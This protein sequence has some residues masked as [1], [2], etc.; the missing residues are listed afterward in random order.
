MGIPRTSFLFDMPPDGGPRD[1]VSRLEDDDFFPM[2][3][4]K[5]RF[6]VCDE[7]LCMEG[8]E[9]IPPKEPLANCAWSWG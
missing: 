9:R 5:D 3:E 2:P 6:D 7:T 1:D 4:K 8:D